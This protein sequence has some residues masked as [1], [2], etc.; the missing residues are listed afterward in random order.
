MSGLEKSEW[1]SRNESTL[2]I[3]R[4]QLSLIN[5]QLS[6]RGS[7]DMRLNPVRSEVKRVALGGKSGGGVGERQHLLCNL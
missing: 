2:F 6:H 3:L 7:L 5:L 4:K 1:L